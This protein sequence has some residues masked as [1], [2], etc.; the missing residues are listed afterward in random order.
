MI[1]NNGHLN[2]LDKNGWISEN[3]CGFCK[4]KSTEDAVNNLVDF[5][6]RYTTVINALDSSLG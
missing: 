2:F 3:Q 1:I 5:V 6:V 4:H